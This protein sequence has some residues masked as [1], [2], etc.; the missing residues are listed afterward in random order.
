MQTLQWAIITQ[1]QEAGIINLIIILA[2]PIFITGMFGMFIE[3]KLLKMKKMEKIL[4][5]RK[6]QM[7]KLK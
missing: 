7:K 4:K 1:Y 2:F 5:M 6:D 3:I